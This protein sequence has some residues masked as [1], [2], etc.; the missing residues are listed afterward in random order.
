M[1]RHSAHVDAGVLAELDAGLIVGRRATRIHAHLAGCERCAHVS[2]GLSAVSV[3]LTAVPQQA[4]PEAV[5][6]RLT[7]TIAAEAAA[8]AGAAR[9]GSVAASPARLAGQE[10]NNHHP[11]KIRVA[12]PRGAWRSLTG[13]RGPVAARAFAAAAAVCLLAAGGYTVSQLASHGSSAPSNLGLRGGRRPVLGPAQSPKGGFNRPGG[14]IVPS[15]GTLEPFSIVK[16]GTDYTSSQLVA[17]IE[18]E[19][20]KVASTRE[21]APTSAQDA[22]VQRV[23]G[24]VRPTMVD[25]ADYNGKPATVIALAPIDSQVSQ[26]WIVGSACSETNSDILQYV[27]LP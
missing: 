10:S 24:G 1:R 25:T 19:L 26:A 7:A 22:C 27:K 13:P 23:T 11:E 14:P 15:S 16:S 2:A 21:Y 5:T 3:L 20:A 8:R 18:S 9:A 12:S 6:R 17:Q 4:M